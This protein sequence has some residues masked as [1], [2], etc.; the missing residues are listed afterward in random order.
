MR[1]E[2]PSGGGKESWGSPQDSDPGFGAR[3]ELSDFPPMLVKKL[4][5]TD[6]KSIAAGF[7]EY[8]NF[9]RWGLDFNSKRL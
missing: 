1:K 4:A 6:L 5:F 7:A 9:E 3:K 2:L 8:V